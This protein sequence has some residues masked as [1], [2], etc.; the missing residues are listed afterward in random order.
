MEKMV[1]RVAARFNVSFMRWGTF[2]CSCEAS[3]RMLSRDSE[4]DKDTLE[5]QGK[6]KRLWKMELT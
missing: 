2:S 5:M 6:G 4:Y 3:V 1:W